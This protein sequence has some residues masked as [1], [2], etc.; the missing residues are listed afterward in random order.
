MTRHRPN[1]GHMYHVELVCTN[2]C[3]YE[4]SISSP[5]TYWFNQ[6]IPDECPNCSAP[7]KTVGMTGG[8]SA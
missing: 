5:T 7:V 3:G 2:A 6:N 1:H 4:V 8:D